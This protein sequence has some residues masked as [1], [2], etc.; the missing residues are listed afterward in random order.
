MSDVNFENPPIVEVGMAVYFENIS[1]LNNINLSA[2]AFELA[3]LLNLPNLQ[4]TLYADSRIESEIQKSG[5]SL[6]FSQGIQKTGIRILARDGTSYVD[7][8]DNRFASTWIKQQECNYPRFESLKE[9]FF[10]RLKNFCIGVPS[11]GVI[12]PK[13]TQAGIQYVNLIDDD[14][15]RAH[16]LLNLVDLSSFQNHEAI[17]FYTRQRLTAKPEVGRLYLALDTVMNFEN[18]LTGQL[19]QKR[20]LKF[21]LTFRGEPKEDGTVGVAN[22]IDRGHESIVNTFAMSLSKEGIAAFGGKA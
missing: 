11:L 16:T 18:S 22:F 1:F 13:F 14:D 12:T 21:A 9:Q 20:K 6:N 10:E 17:H 5:Q 2:R 15:T 19:E 4:Q 7:I 3:K 8:Q